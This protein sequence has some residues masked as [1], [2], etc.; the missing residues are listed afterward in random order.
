MR[1]LVTVKANQHNQ[2]QA[3]HVFRQVE[4]RFGLENAQKF[5]DF[6]FLFQRDLRTVVDPD[7]TLICDIDCIVHTFKLRLVEERLEKIF[8]AAGT[9]VDT[10]RPLKGA[11]RKEEEEF[12]CKFL[13]A[14]HA[15]LIPTLFLL[16]LRSRMEEEQNV[17][18]SSSS[19]LERSKHPPSFKHDKDRESGLAALFERYANLGEGAEG[20][21]LVLNGKREVLDTLAAAAA[22]G[23]R[24]T[25]SKNVEQ[26]EESERDEETAERVDILNLFFDVLPCREYLLTHVTSFFLSPLSILLDD[27]LLPSLVGVATE[28]DEH[29]AGVSKSGGAPADLV[30]VA[31]E[32]DEHQREPRFVPG[33]SKSG[34]EPPADHRGVT[35]SSSL[36]T[37]SQTALNPSSLYFFGH[38]V[39]GRNL[40]SD[41]RRSK[42]TARCVFHPD[43]VFPKNEDDHPTALQLPPA[44][45][46]TRFFIEVG[47]H[48]GDCIL[49][50]VLSGVA[51]KGV[52]VDAHNPAVKAVEKTMA[53]LFSTTE[54]P[55]PA[56]AAGVYVNSS[57]SSKDDE[58]FLAL[59]S[60]SS[61][62][63]TKSRFLADDAHNNQCFQLL[64]ADSVAQNAGSTT[65]S[66]NAFH[67][68][69]FSPV[70]CAVADTKMSAGSANAPAPPHSPA[71]ATVVQMASLDSIVP[72]EVLDRA[73]EMNYR[74]TDPLGA[75]GVVDAASSAT[76]PSNSTTSSC[77]LYMRL[78]RNEFAVLEG[79]RRLLKNCEFV[80]LS[81]IHHE[82]YLLLRKWLFKEAGFVQ[83]MDL[84]EPNF[85]R[86]YYRNTLFR[87]KFADVDGSTS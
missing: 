53:D 27:L 80:M 23:N 6:N 12:V 28:M 29:Q 37:T 35:Q 76:W 87:R 44:R 54:K 40:E 79:A 41:S 75:P 62:V 81:G 83:L 24:D 18:N 26:D 77:V 43:L 68:A 20:K 50:W 11:D 4:S 63:V 71:G 58:I 3:V 69:A 15:A 67:S 34:G 65:I 46:K 8:A 1:S 59:Q 52:F 85:P 57:S 21:T 84:G 36:S 86:K 38:V 16:K 64:D 10:P 7:A 13:N 47:G 78:A 14:G 31:T 56:P 60:A 25:S 42:D 48:Q 70:E 45:N 22:S 55:S 73:P 9:K 51:E 33:V 32:M 72:P 61:L 2:E 66:I 17:G 74:Y 39:P 82:D 5:L 30:G 19:T 49:P